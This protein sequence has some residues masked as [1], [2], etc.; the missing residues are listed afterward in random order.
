MGMPVELPEDCV[1]LLHLQRG[2]IAR[3]QAETAGLAPAL[4]RAKVRS[5]RWQ[6]L[7][8]GV[9]AAFTGE[10]SRAAWQWA[11]VLR[12]GAG[13]ALSHYTAAELD[14]LTDRVSDVI[15]VTIGHDRKAQLDDQAGAPA[16]PGIMLHRSRRLAVSRHPARTPPRTRIAETVIDLT[17]L[18]ASFDDVLGWLSRGCGRRLTT[19]DQLRSAVAARPRMRWRREI[20]IALDDVAAGAHSPLEYRYVHG[21]ERAHGLPAAERQIQLSTEAGRRYLDNLYAAF[22]VGVELDGQAYHPAEA[23]WDD[24]HRDNTCAV[25]GLLILRY[26]WTDVTERRC[27]T[28]TELARLLT[29]RGWPGRL[30]RC[31]P[32]CTA[33]LP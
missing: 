6:P 22:G 16:A 2:V 32:A 17:Q 33:A 8:R 13:A 11:A 15:H 3:W 19:S 30:R 28:A 10:P 14:R 23:R 7:Y 29:Q 5:G 31:G 12:A 9:Y 18:A 20:L 25:V 24:Q 1:A 26:S 21:V 27:S 4:A